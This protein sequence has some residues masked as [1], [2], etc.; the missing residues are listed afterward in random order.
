MKRV[1]WKNKP[2]SQL[3]VTIPVGSGMQEGDIVDVNKALVKK[4][5][6]SAIVGDLF[7]Y[8]HLQII[9]FAKSVSDYNIC[10]VLTDEAV[11]EHKARPIA[12]LKERKAIILTLNCVDRV[13]V[14]RSID[15]T[16]NLKRIHEEFPDAKII[17]VHGSDWR[18]V[19]GSD[20]IKKIGG[21]IAQ[22]PYYGRLSNFK[23]INNLIENKDKFIDAA[24]FASLIRGE[25][26]HDSEYEMGNRRIISTKADTLKAL[27][28]ILKKSRIEKIYSFTVS[29]WRNIKGR[30]LSTIG[31]EFAP[32]NI[33]VRSSAVNEDSINSSM[34]GCFESV[35]S[36]NPKNKNDVESAIKRVV[37]SYKIKMSESSFNQVLIQHQTKN[38]VMSGVVFTR[39]LETNSPYYTI[40]YDDSSGK[41]TNVTKGLE[42]KT[43]K[44]SKFIEIK[45]IPKNMLPLI[46]AVKEIEEK[47]PGIGLDIEFAMNKEQEVIIFQVRPMAA[48]IKYESD[49]DKVK[50][51]IASLKKRLK[52]LSKRKPHL[53]GEWTIFADMPDWNPAE[54]I[55]D[56]PNYLDYS[57]YDYLITDSAWHGARTSQGY[58]D[59]D[60]A[61]LVVLFGNKPYVDVRNSFNS[62][63]PASISQKL[64]EKLVSF[65][66]NKLKKNPEMQDKVE[67]EIA[68][69]CYDLCFEEKSKELLE[70]NFTTGEIREL[71]KYLIELTNNLVL[72]S[73]ANISNDLESLKRMEKSRLDIKKSISLTNDYVKSLLDNVKFL[74]DDCR[75]RGTMQFSRLARLAFVGKIILKSLVD[76]KIINQD[77]Y[78]KFMNS[79]R[80][81][82]T[83]INEDFKLLVT[84]TM[85]KDEFIKK[86]Y[87]L[88]PG[89]YDIT[90]LRYDSNPNL[91]KISDI[92]FSDE[93]GSRHFELD[94]STEKEITNLLKKEGLKFNAKELLEFVKSALE[95]REFSKF[96]FTKN[97]SDAIE[98][99]ALAGEKMGFTRQ[100]LATL[101]V[102][103][104]FNA[105]AKNKGKLTQLWK[106]NITLRSKE[107]EINKKLILPP[108]IASE[109]D[110]DVI[111]YYVPRPNYITHKKI[112]GK[113][114]KIDNSNKED[115]PDI[116]GNIVMLENGDP[117]YDW[118]FT[119]NPAGLITKYGGVASHMS[120]RCAEFG[121]PAAIGTGALFDQISNADYIALDCK[122][123]NIKIIR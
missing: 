42:S 31:K 4:V 28:P 50:K 49:D 20:Y 61:K 114:V 122:F 8:G 63:V 80:T 37:D 99:I 89:S 94:K 43:L 90:S 34:A 118:I 51:G 35:L 85:S 58:Y 119:R 18:Y 48:S 112:E 39:T 22:P 65:Y 11:E 47:I 40:N 13:I 2:N 38:I 102:N 116:S 79:I 32:D 103:E 81:V 25:Y 100:E 36:V 57:L 27:Q 83:E 77:F 91:L 117:G 111:N 66:L 9:Q 87:H 86:Y 93:N 52:E 1:I 6:Y 5:A 67:F 88:R 21:K 95:A 68:Y 24:N 45:D 46:N 106:E 56:N 60:P 44:I 82:A 17:L 110:F 96:E 7:H 121:V 30:V 16:E 54:I 78:H 55:G 98:L 59:V 113:I 3:C 33:I 101:S 73:K 74:L 41:T 84:G 14:Q 108:I 62:F 92:K 123:K 19:Y 75:E 64:R 71:K 105:N 15:P 10:G 23:I 26:K 12:N 120:I 104:I 76:K 69:T 97:L 115:I 29:D 53:S 109:K 72:N 107:M 70:S